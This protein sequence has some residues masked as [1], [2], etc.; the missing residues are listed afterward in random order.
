MRGNRGEESGL[1]PV[2]LQGETESSLESGTS[3]V[4]AHVFKRL[5]TGDSPLFSVIIQFLVYERLSGEAEL[6]QQTKVL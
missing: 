2:G 4:T 5:S 3:V 1:L 6:L